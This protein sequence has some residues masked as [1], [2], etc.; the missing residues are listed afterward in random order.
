MLEFYSPR[1]YAVPPF[2]RTANN[3]RSLNSVGDQPLEQ[4]ELAGASA[5]RLQSHHEAVR[6]FV[7]ALAALEQQDAGLVA[8][9]LRS[10]DRALALAPNH[11]F[12]RYASLG[13]YQRAAHAKPDSA[14]A[15]IGLAIALQY[16]GLHDDAIRHL[17]EA[18]RISPDNAKALERLRRLGLSP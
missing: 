7:S 1:A 17:R 11:G 14:D 3:L 12:L 10:L 18:L 15:H 4:V 9:S 13:A 5:P 8:E 16:R 2:Q 6:E